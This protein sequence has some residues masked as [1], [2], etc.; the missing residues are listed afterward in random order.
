MVQ[1]MKENDFLL[2]QEHCLYESHIDKL[3]ELDTCVDVVGKSSMDEHVP[4]V[5]RPYGGC[6]IVYNTSV[7]GSISEV[8]CSHQ[9]LCG[10]YLTMN[11][12]CCILILNAYMPVDNFRHDENFAIYMEVISEVEEIIHRLDPTHVIFGGDLNTDLIRG[13]PHSIAL[14]RFIHEFDMTTCINLEIADVPYTY[15]GPRS[16]SRIDHFLASSAIGN[17][18]LACKITDNHLYSD[19]VPLCVSFTINVDHTLFTE[20]TPVHKPAWHKANDEQKSRYKLMLEQNLRNIQYDFN[21]LRCTNVNCTE[22]FH[23]LTEFYLNIINACINASDKCIP[24]TGSAGKQSKRTPGWSDQVEEL[25]RDSLMWHQHWRESGQPH[26][27]PVAELHRI[28]RARYHRAVRYVLKDSNFIRTVKMAESIVDN[29]TR[30]LFKE[31]RK[32]KGRNNVKTGCVDGCTGDD[33]ISDLFGEKYKNLYNSVPYDEQEMESIASE[34]N[35]RL[36]TETNVYKLCVDE[37]E[38]AVQRIKLGKSDGEEGLSSDHIINGPHLLIVVLTNVFNCMLVHGVSP[39]SMISGTMVPIPKGKRKLLCCSDNYRAITLSSIIGKVFD[40]VVLIK[41]QGALYS[42]DLQ[43]GFKPHVSTTHCTF[44]TTEIISYYNFNRS[45]VYTVL[46]DATKAFDRVNYCKL[47][48]KLLDRKLSPVV[49]RLLLYMYT[50]QSL[51]VRWG[52]A[53][54]ARFNV[55]NGVKQG[56]VLSPILFAVYMDDLFERLRNSGV[57]CHIGNHFAGGVGYADDLKLIA[58]SNKGLQRLVDICERYANEYDVIFNGAK[59]VF[60]VFRGRECKKVTN[61]HIGVN[62]VMLKNS[63]KALHL[64]HSLCTDDKDSVIH[65]AIAQFW[66]SFNLFRA[67]FGHIHPYVQCKLFKQYCCSFYGSPL[68]LL[69]SHVVSDVCVAWRRAL[70]RIW[71][72]PPMTHRNIVA[73]VSDCKP[74]DISLKQRFCKFSNSIA[75]HGSKVLKSIVNAARSNPFSVYCN[76][77]VEISS[78]YDTDIDECYSVIQKKWYDSISCE[79]RSNVGV[80]RELIDVRDGW[81]RCESM[82]MDDVMFIIE[83]VCVN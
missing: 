17:S 23:G 6:A 19:H 41:E 78:M 40:W 71:R 82:D 28:S 72:L 27:G 56:G 24:M 12:N 16:N 77:Y 2:L 55:V 33:D 60:M 4:L 61:C 37:V 69:A 34:I 22:H 32:I 67:D 30:D 63:H 14:S 5:G 36:D 43:F 47:F 38:K 83:D 49:L 52:T 65:A 26:H 62:N 81:K 15:I 18:V 76:N 42:S 3:K 57:G 11:S 45:N 21:V 66:A 13:S 39:D 50:N 25:R 54:S 59:S 35:S 74:L 80:V 1:I 44:A 7:N 10:V 48:K 53:V 75:V 68:W 31:A 8:K 70:K 46:L 51:Q 79:L 58:P 9:R 29:R 20:R 64:G 73:I